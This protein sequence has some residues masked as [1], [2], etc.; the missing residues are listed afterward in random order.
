MHPLEVAAYVLL[1]ACPPV[2]DTPHGR[3]VVLQLGSSAVCLL[4]L[5]RGCPVWAGAAEVC[6]D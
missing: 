1:L 5:V 4:D 6:L 2:S 3:P